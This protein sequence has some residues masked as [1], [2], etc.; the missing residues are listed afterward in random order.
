M[1]FPRAV[2]GDELQAHLLAG[3]FGEV[4]AH[5]RPG[6]PADVVQGVE[7]RDI[8]TGADIVLRAPADLLSVLVEH[9][10]H[11]AGLVVRTVSGILQHHGELD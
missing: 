4:E 8:R 9:T 6:P 2:V 10:H 1:A 5:I 7:S 3:V 11:K